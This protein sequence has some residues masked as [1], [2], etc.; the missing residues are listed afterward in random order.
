MGSREPCLFCRVFIKCF[1][2]RYHVFNPCFF[3]FSFFFVF[4]YFSFVF[5]SFP[6]KNNGKQLKTIG[7]HCFF[8]GNQWK[9]KEN[10][11]KPWKTIENL[12][13][14]TEN[15]EHQ[16]NSSVRKTHLFQICG[17]F[18][19]EVLTVMEL[20]EVSADSQYVPLKIIPIQNLEQKHGARK[21]IAVL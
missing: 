5:L 18:S 2:L 20:C 12:Q 11:R 8:H 7:F 13:K 14:T 1:R 10:N 19:K 6:L 15:W 21:Q 16:G 17:K 9:T 4:H 3:C